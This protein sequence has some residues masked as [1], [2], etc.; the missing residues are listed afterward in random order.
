M[1][2]PRQPPKSPLLEMR[3]IEIYADVDPVKSLSFEIGYTYIVAE[4]VSP[5]RVTENVTDVPEYKVDAR[6]EYASPTLGS[7]ISLT[8]ANYGESF[9]QLPTPADWENE[10][11]VNEGYTVLGARFAQPFLSK[12]EAYLTV[13]NL[14]D[15]D[16]ESES[17]YPAQ[18]R[19][20][21]LGASYKY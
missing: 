13:S 7:R 18:G 3:G 1:T 11:V 19:I 17:G 12:W 8:M 20:F 14:L 4:D 10:I 6:L 16:Y 9:S 21:W 5:G 2:L 15:E